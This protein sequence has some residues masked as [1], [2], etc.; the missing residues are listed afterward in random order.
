[1]DLDCPRCDWPAPIGTGARAVCTHCGFQWQADPPAVSPRRPLDQHPD[2]LGV[3]AEPLARIRGFM[4]GPQTD[5]DRAAA[6]RFLDG[7][8]ER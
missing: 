3:A 7:L 4:S 5:A 6:R 1:M 8:A 2:D